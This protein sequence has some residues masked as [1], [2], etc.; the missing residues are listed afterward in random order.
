MMFLNVLNEDALLIIQQAVLAKNYQ[1]I[2][3]PVI[4]F[5]GSFSR[6]KYPQQKL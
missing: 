3:A 6:Q 2:I 4:L 1:L 5:T